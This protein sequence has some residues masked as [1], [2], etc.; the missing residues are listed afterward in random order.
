MLTGVPFTLALSF[1]PGAIYQ[2]VQGPDEPWK[3]IATD[4]VPCCQHKVLKFGNVQISP[5]NS[6]KLST[7]PVVC[8]KGKPNSTLIVVILYCCISISLLASPLARWY[9]ILRHLCVKPDRPR[10][11]L[12]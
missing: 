6:S 9:R 12:L 3:G 1:D 7:N 10:T 5:A 4:T 8:L 11:T 2:K